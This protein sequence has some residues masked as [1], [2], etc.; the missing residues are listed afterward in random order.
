M[1]PTQNTTNIQYGMR[2]HIA[3][4][5][6]RLTID[7]DN[8]NDT[9]KEFQKSVKTG[10]ACAVGK[11][12]SYTQCAINTS[13]HKEKHNGEKNMLQLE[14]LLWIQIAGIIGFCAAQRRAWRIQENNWTIA[15]TV[16]QIPQLNLSW[17][18]ST[19][20]WVRIGGTHFLLQCW[21]KPVLPSCDRSSEQSFHASMHHKLCPTRHILIQH[22]QSPPQ[23][24]RQRRSQQ[25]QQPQ[26][27]CTFM[28]QTSVIYWRHTT[29][30]PESAP[31]NR[32]FRPATTPPQC[33]RN[34]TC[35]WIWQRLHAHKLQPRWCSMR[36]RNNNNRSANCRST[37]DWHKTVETWTS[38]R[39]FTDAKCRAL[40]DENTHC[41]H[42]TF[43][44]ISFAREIH[45]LF[46]ANKTWWNVTPPNTKSCITHTTRRLGMHP[47]AKQQNATVSHIANSWQSLLMLNDYVRQML[48][49][50]GD[51]TLHEEQLTT[52]RKTHAQK[53]FS[54]LR[55]WM[56][57][58][59][60]N[61]GARTLLAGRR[62]FTRQPEGENNHFWGSRPTKTPH[63][64]NSTRRPPERK[65]RTEK[66]KGNGKKTRNLGATLP[67]GPR[68]SGPGTHP[69]GPHTPSS[70]KM[71]KTDRGQSRWDRG[72]SR[73]WQK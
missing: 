50:H 29:T 54:S 37:W 8:D 52:K 30:K 25:Q 10:V 2:Y 15:G 58:K 20:L 1:P 51:T 72:Q 73:S 32:I 60:K 65:K 44:R 62:G 11:V 64:Q 35:S 66:V 4:F 13:D 12:C 5:D 22:Q 3:W 63:H 27:T 47:I 43:T 68:P 28:K 21:L 69:S 14:K 36:G 34:A 61:D 42:H 33:R 38:S 6:E 67:S 18:L 70:P 17:S 49:T 41:K 39:K 55:N 56:P 57:K 19:P 23:Q 9:L 71:P 31:R 46:D 24:L 7:N 59:R 53:L 45:T 26:P 40:S 48:N 16:W